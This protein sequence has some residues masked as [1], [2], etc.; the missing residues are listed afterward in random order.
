M[1][2]FTC[3]FFFLFQV[4]V[5]EMLIF[6]L[7]NGFSFKHIWG[8]IMFSLI[9]DLKQFVENSDVFAAL[10]DV[11]GSPGGLWSALYSRWI[12][13]Y[14]SLMFGKLHL[15]AMFLI[16]FDPSGFIT[17]QGSFINTRKCKSETSSLETKWSS[18]AACLCAWKS[19]DSLNVYVLICNMSLLICKEDLFFS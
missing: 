14:P 4:S 12:W 19:S 2:G 15:K 3:C 7:S 1:S 11:S 18:R 13:S 5:I 8:R 16:Y 10:T 6:R 17:K 9:S